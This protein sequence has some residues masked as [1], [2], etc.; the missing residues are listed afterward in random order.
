MTA[1]ARCVHNCTRLENSAGSCGAPP[2]WDRFITPR[3]VGTL[4]SLFGA[5]HRQRR[6]IVTI[7]SITVAT[8]LKGSTQTFLAWRVHSTS[9]QV[10]RSLLVRL[11]PPGHS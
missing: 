2:K 4:A 11:L 6:L 5:G 8:G 10:G 3:R 9:C 7:L 1:A